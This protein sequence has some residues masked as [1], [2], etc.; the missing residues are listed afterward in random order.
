[1]TKFIEFLHHK[2]LKL[3]IYSLRVNLTFNDFFVSYFL[4]YP[5]K[6]YQN[7]PNFICSQFQPNP[8]HSFSKKIRFL[9]FLKTVFSH[10]VLRSILSFLPNFVIF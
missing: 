10:P 2:Y 4:R 8:C 3:E 5:K 9:G 1:M 7:D 6:K